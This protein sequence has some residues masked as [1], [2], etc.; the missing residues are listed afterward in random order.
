MAYEASRAQGITVPAL[1][2][3]YI[4]Q[5]KSLEVVDTND[6]KVDAVHT[7]TD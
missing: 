5:I 4:K 2:D 7:A 3:D 6:P 1:L